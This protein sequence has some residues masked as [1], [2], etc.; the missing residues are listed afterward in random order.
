M[1][2]HYDRDCRFSAG[3]SASCAGCTVCIALHADL[4]TMYCSSGDPGH[5]GHVCWRLPPNVIPNLLECSQSSYMFIFDISITSCI[6][7]F[8]VKG[9]F[10]D[11]IALFWWLWSLVSTFTSCE[12]LINSFTVRQSQLSH[13]EAMTV[14]HILIKEKRRLSSANRFIE[15]AERPGVCVCVK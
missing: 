9:T 7:R 4:M 3:I 8:H 12:S 11:F 1:D 13:S 15:D 10:E 14:T 5:P 6:G 2:S